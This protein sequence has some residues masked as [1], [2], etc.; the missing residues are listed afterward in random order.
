MSLEHHVEIKPALEKLWHRLRNEAQ[1]Q[2][3][4]AS[5]LLRFVN[6]KHGR[7]TLPAPPVFVQHVALHQPLFQSLPHLPKSI[8]SVDSWQV[9]VAS[10][11]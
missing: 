4:D 8:L 11:C 2:R 1:L 3:E 5:Q 10:G 7:V 9:Q 6:Y